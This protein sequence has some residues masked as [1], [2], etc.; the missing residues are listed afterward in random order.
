MDWFRRDL[1]NPM[2]YSS[3]AGLPT[4]LS[5]YEWCSNRENA[6]CAWAQADVPGIKF[7]A[8]D[9]IPKRFYD[10]KMFTTVR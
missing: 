6:Y 2:K 1:S 3:R 10:T 4:P 5:E 8:N 7:Q 9:V